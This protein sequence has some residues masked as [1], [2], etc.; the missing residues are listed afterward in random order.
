VQISQIQQLT[1][2]MVRVTV[3][4]EALIDFP[5]PGPASH[6]KVFFPGLE[7]EAGRPI[8]RTYTPRRWDP[9]T[10]ELDVDF[11]LHGT[12]IGSTWAS[13][14]RVGDSAAVGR[15]GG[16]YEPDPTADWLLIA[17]DDSA[18]PAIGTLVEALPA[19]ARAQV[20]I[21]VE[22]AEEE[23]PLTSRA[24]LDL[25]WLHRKD[26]AAQV[27]SLL[28]AAIRDCRIPEASAKVWVACEA[29]I[30]RNIR[31]HLLHERGLARE[32]VYTH[33]YWKDGENNHP[34]HDLGKEI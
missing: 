7:A 2:N 27:G 20:F 10:G 1:P 15:P 31:T 12:G 19:S 6:F 30:M 4:G 23:Q 17:G 5:T 26:P 14:A 8:N 24:R 34:D 3:T 18:L 13:Q 21:E 33:G 16:A 32:A 29:S 11:L 22:N 28:Q 9:A 25:T